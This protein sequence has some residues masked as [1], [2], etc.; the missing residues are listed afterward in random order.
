MQVAQDDS[1]DTLLFDGT[2]TSPNFRGPDLPDGVYFLR[3]RAIDERGLEGRDAVSR[4]VL[5][6]RPE[7]PVLIAPEFE[8]VVPEEQPVFQWAQQLGADSYRFQLA[9]DESFR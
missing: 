3:L 6:A 4:F 2:F 8:G 7:P 9:T 1:F 5:N